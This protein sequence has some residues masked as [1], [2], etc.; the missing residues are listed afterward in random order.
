MNFED[1]HLPYAVYG[2]LRPDCGND[3]LWRN[4]ANVRDGKWF[5]DGYRL[6]AHRSGMFPFALP[7]PF[8]HICVDLIDPLPHLQ[9]D[10]RIDFDLLEGYPNF[11]NRIKVDVHGENSQCVAWLY[12]PNDSESYEHL[13]RVSD[14]NWKNYLINV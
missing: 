4:R 12:T 1:C 5:V 2:S 10:L 7:S 11:Y 8:G 3:G 6:V 14:G 13:P 9:E